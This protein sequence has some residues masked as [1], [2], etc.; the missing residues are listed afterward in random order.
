AADLVDAVV[1]VIRDKAVR[2]VALVARALVFG[3]IVLVSS[4]LMAVVISIALVR[5]LTVYA[6][7]GRVW[8]ADLVVGAVFV[9]LGLLA[10]SKRRGPASGATVR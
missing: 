2:P 5:I 3:I 10:W 9:F 1:A 7:S 6:F 4:L 8:L